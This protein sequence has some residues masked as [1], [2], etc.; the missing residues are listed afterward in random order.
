[1]DPRP[2]PAIR[3]LTA[4]EAAALLRVHPDHVRRLIKRG[5]M[6][7]RRIGTTYRVLEHELL[8][9]MQGTW[10]PARPSDPASTWA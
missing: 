8:A 1:M 2:T 6:P 7:G 5:E 3:I 4:D 10:R 9:Y